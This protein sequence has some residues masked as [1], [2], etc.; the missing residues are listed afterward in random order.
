MTALSLM[1]WLVCLGWSPQFDV[2]AAAGARSE[3]RVSRLAIYAEPLIDL[4]LGPSLVVDLASTALFLELSYLPVL[5]FHLRQ[6]E[7]LSHQKLDVNHQGLVS[8]SGRVARLRYTLDRDSEAYKQVY[9]Q[10]TAVERIN[11]QAVDL[12]IERPHLRNGAAIA[13]LNTLT[14]VLINLRMLQRIRAHQP[15]PE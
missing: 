10:R 13:N 1:G 4:E 7:E 5:V 2:S 14:Y 12:G 11:S 8:L 15:I 3:G 6:P 9:K